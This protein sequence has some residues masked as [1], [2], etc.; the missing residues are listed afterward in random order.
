MGTA[1]SAGSD[2]CGQDRLNTVWDY[3]GRSRKGCPASLSGWRVS[4]I[5]MR[6]EAPWGDVSDSAYGSLLWGAAKESQLLVSPSL[7]F[8]HY[9][10]HITLI[11]Q[12]SKI[13]C[14]LSS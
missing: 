9:Y 10:N 5:H 14:N 13:A 6:F 7:F 2:A 4:R 8:I 3:S 11:M 12:K 1:C